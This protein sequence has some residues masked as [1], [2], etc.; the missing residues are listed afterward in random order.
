MNAPDKT[1]PA[2]EP[3]DKSLYIN[4]ELSLLE[5]N[6]RVL[7]QAADE[8][9]P[10]LERWRFL[11]ISSSNIDEFFEIRVSGVKQQVAASVQFTGPEELRP[12]DLLR[13][14]HNTTRELVVE[15]YRLFND[16]LAPALAKDG[17]RILRR[18]EWTPEQAAWVRD[19]FTREVQPLLTP[20]G[21]DPAHPFPNVANKILNF[22][23]Q[24]EGHD[25]FSRDIGV[26][27]VQAPRL[28]PRIVRLPAGVAGCP[29]DF[30][31]LSA[32]MHANIGALFPSMEVKGCF[33]F[34]VTRNSD[35]WVDEEEVEDLAE[36]LRYELPRR[37][38]GGAVRLEVAES[39]PPEIAQMLL[40]HFDLGEDDLYRVNGP[41]NLSRTMLLYN[42]VDAPALK[43][44]PHTPSVPQRL[45]SGDE[46]FDTLRKRDIVL[47]HPY[48]SFTPVLDFVHQA[49][50]DP[51]V[52]AVMT[53][54]YRTGAHSEI[55][56]ALFQ[57]A[58]A[59]KE[60]TVVIELRA[61][62]D[63]AANINLA[64]HLQ[65]AGVQVMYGVVGYKTHAKMMLILRREEGQL[66]RY[67]H[68][69][70]GNYHTST[71]RAYTDLSLM[72]S[73]EEICDDVHKLFRELTAPG[74]IPRMK[75]LYQSP[76]TLNDWL[77]GR[78]GEQAE[79]ASQG[80]PSRIR[81]KLNALSDP[82]L[83]KALYVASMAGVPIDLIVRGGCCLT[84]G[85][86]G[87]SENIRVRSII[88][89]F[90]EHSRIFCFGPNDEYVY[91]S[92]ADGLQRNLHRRVEVCFPILDPAIKARVISEF[93]ELPLADNSQSWL[94]QPAGTWQRVVQGNEEQRSVQEILIA[95]HSGSGGNA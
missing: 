29:H 79:L 65:S 69:G 37:Q 52:V 13:R 40:D 22:F 75:Q 1:G 76:F 85:V 59:G 63:E 67:A 34:R 88:G 26:A 81:A 42:L 54:L 31:L 66:R 90:L 44:P 28:L 39:C 92:S 91:A 2:I 16:V 48:Q 70:T 61:R 27:I 51:N 83:I 38:F 12:Q 60:V 68:L 33:Q 47:H 64:T 58:R 8:S 21:L 77:L 23:V 17:V 55:T 15:Q 72:T 3:G 9:V 82:V 45:A 53:T 56:E 41:V 86:P 57:A 49:K 5:F 87:V 30:V 43:Y 78:I 4:R 93:I 94:L 89:R 74:E 80:K 73:N 10:L 20:V 24:L 19:Y 50:T 14:I 32:V 62:F 36:A 11:T 7:A 84:P 18:T 46:I 6:R 71:A 25:A 95:K 35:M